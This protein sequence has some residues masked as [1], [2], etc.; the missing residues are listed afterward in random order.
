MPGKKERKGGGRK[1]EKEGGRK[2]RRKEEKQKQETF[3]FLNK[4]SVVRQKV[5]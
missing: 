5:Q 4:S 2:G 3:C 1:G